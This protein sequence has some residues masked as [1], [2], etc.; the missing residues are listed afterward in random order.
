MKNMKKLFALLVAALV[1]FLHRKNL[2]RIFNHEENKIK[3]G[4]K[5]K[6]SEPEAPIQESVQPVKEEKEENEG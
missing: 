3:L 1:I 5:K 4:K 2:V 6:V